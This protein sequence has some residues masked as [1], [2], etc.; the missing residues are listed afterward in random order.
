[1]TKQTVYLL[2]HGEAT[3]NVQRIWTFK[4]SLTQTG[5]AQARYWGDYFRDKKLTVIYA[6]TVT[7]TTQTAKLISRAVKLTVTASR[8]IVEAN[9]GK[10]MEHSVDLQGKRDIEEKLFSAWEKGEWTVSYP[11]GES[12]ADIK[13]RLERLVE[14]FPESGTLLVVSHQMP[15]AV[16]LWAFCS[17]HPATFVDCMVSRASMVRLERV[18]N[19]SFKIRQLN[20]KPQIA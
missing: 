16:F 18:G 2:R 7:R 10:F 9:G 8:D 12:F 4:G 20:V 19:K 14:K 11:I 6:S 15:I 3:S 1:M 17:N 5:R 13:S